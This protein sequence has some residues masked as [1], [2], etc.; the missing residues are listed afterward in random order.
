M[1]I[2]RLKVRLV[3]YTQVGEPYCWYPISYSG[4]PNGAANRL[5]ITI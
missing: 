2:D 3:C 5:E 1:A 4:R